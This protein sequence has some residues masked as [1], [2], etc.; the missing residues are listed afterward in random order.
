MSLVAVHNSKDDEIA[1]L[2]EQLRQL[3]EEAAKESEETTVN[4]APVVPPTE[5]GVVESDDILS[6]RKISGNPVPEMLSESWKETES[7]SEG[8]LLSNIGSVVGVF[9][10][11][12]GIYF[13]AQVPVGQDDY[14]KY[15]AARPST[16]IDLGDLN[17]SKSPSP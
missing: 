13:F 16:Q 5:V 7:E 8:S 15:S 10:L 11:L 6:S 4:S 2:E 14:I 1:K 17:T 9:A 12:I 3:K